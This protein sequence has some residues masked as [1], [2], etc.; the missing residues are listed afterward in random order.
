M[1]E[2]LRWHNATPLGVARC[3]VA[4]DEYDGYFIPAGTT[5]VVNVWWAHL[6]QTYLS[7]SSTEATYRSITHDPERY[8][9]PDRFMP[10]RYLRDGKLNPE[11]ADPSGVIFGSGRR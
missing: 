5:I 8:S 7:S 4:D 10:E 3:S 6:L 2:L 11:A 1:K 9:E